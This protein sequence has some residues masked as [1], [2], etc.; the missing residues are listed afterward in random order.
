[1]SV[2][3]AIDVG[4]GNT[5]F[6]MA[7]SNEQGGIA[8][9]VF[10]S[11]VPEPADV[12]AGAQVLGGKR[13][14]VT[15]RVES[16]SY[17]VG[18]DV[19]RVMGTRDGRSLHKDYSGTDE[20]L[21]LTRGALSYM[22]HDKIDFLVVG[23]PVNASPAKY[24]ALEQRLKGEHEVA[25]GRKVD[26]KHVLVVAQPMGG[27]LDHA[28]QNNLV[29]SISDMTS[30]LV[31]VGF[32]TLDWVVARGTEP[33]SARS[34]G[35]DAGVSEVLRRVNG[36][37]R[38]KLNC[39]DISINRLDKALRDG[40]IRIFGESYQMQEFLP[41]AES[42]INEGLNALQARV[43]ASDDIDS[44]V[45]CGGGASLYEPS[46]KERFPRHKVAV[47]QDPVFANVRGFQLLG[48]IQAR[49][50]AKLQAQAA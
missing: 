22:G 14:T 42:A 38:K 46:V 7:G 26:V 48:E 20:Y 23:L 9:R 39:D 8:C 45:L 35:Y 18:P 6:T 1:M 32:F 29:R 41:A 27:F 4:F 16:A 13:N 3:R 2:I 21:A 47:V 44:I 24:Q 49:K 40:T 15:V 34:G 10:P 11:L 25:G 17:E 43:G 5:K 31:D 50:L 30:L 36:A 37:I 28:H 33:I 12:T 19:E